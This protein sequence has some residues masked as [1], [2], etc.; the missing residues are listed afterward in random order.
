MI[1]SN[2][3]V[4][5]LL[6]VLFYFAGLLMAYYGEYLITKK[7]EVCMNSNTEYNDSNNEQIGKMMLFT[8]DFAVE[9]SAWGLLS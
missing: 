1:G 2:P 3:M 7:K 6:F 4:F 9:I 5:F 8:S